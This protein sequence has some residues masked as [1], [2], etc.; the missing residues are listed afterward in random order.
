MKSIAITRHLAASDPAVF[1]EIEQPM[2]T[3]GPRD[4]RVRVHAISVNPVDAK[5]RA[6]KELLGQPVEGGA[7]VLGWDAAGV[8]DAVGAEV[9]LFRPGDRVW[10]AG[11]VTR[12]GSNA[13]FVLV[14]ERITG[15]MPT[16]LGFAEAAALPLTAITAW[17]GLFDRLGLDPDG[18]DAGKRVLVVGGAGGVASIA[19]QLARVAGLQV[20]ATAS[21]PA[22][23][24]WVRAMGAHAVIDHRRDMASELAAHG[25]EVDHVF[26][27]ADTDSHFPALPALLKAQGSAVAIVGSKKPLEL[28]LLMAKSLTFHWELMFTRSMFRTPDMQRQHDLLARV[29]EWVDAG[30]IRS[31]LGRVRSPISVATLREA[32]MQLE[33]GS[34]IG[35]WVIEGF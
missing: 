34:T 20:I 30:R 18:A 22:T 11:D 21:R 1:V 26:L 25:G 9:S 3:P 14:D 33:S 28:G 15:P 23:A 31:T 10:F 13:E 27:A 4:L 6:P 2:P 5:V 17:E 32:H 16:S 8:V 7:R 24:D 35:K 12:P 29:A 19:I